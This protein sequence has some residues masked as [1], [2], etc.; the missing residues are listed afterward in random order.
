MKISEIK[1][2]MS[3]K[4]DAITITG[5]KKETYTLVGMF[6]DLPKSFKY[7]G[8]PYQ[9]YGKFIGYIKGSGQLQEL[10][11]YFYNSDEEVTKEL[12]NRT[13]QVELPMNI[14]RVSATRM[15]KVISDHLKKLHK[16]Y[17][18][19]KKRQSEIRKL[20]AQSTKAND[21]I[22]SL[23][24][25]ISADLKNEIKTDYKN[26]PDST[27][28]LT[29]TKLFSKYKNRHDITDV[30]VKDENNPSLKIEL[31]LTG[32][33]PEYALYLL[34][35]E[36]NPYEIDYEKSNKKLYGLLNVKDRET[37]KSINSDL[38][39]IKGLSY[40]LGFNENGDTGYS[41]KIVAYYTLTIPNRARSGAFR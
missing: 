1:D 30:Y 4:Y 22:Y 7:E 34:R 9:S 6:M 26:L 11:V 27:F 33:Y 31:C 29:A 17:Q 38:S 35:K 8:K 24:K 39:K 14:N 2:G 20:E 37:I 25:T 12:E 40:Y 21:T 5:K 19:E 16:Q 28:Y 3:L 13:S 15:P 23:T 10:Q 41:S 32:R 18:E 36:D